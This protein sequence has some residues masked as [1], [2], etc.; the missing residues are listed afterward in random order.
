MVVL[1]VLAAG[2]LLTDFLAWSPKALRDSSQQAAFLLPGVLDGPTCDGTWRHLPAI[3]YADGHVCNRPAADVLPVSILSGVVATLAEVLKSGQ[4]V[5]AARLAREQCGFVLSVSTLPAVTASSLARRLLVKLMTRM[6]LALLPLAPA[7]WQRTTR[8]AAL[9]ATLSKPPGSSEY[10]AQ[11]ASGIGT[12]TAAGSSQSLDSSPQSAA[13]LS[14]TGHGAALGQPH[15]AGDN[16][17]KSAVVTISD[18]VEDITGEL[19][20]ALRNSDTVVR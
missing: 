6:A 15:K 18:A 9:H 2:E 17:D 19:L 3:S 5:Q 7:T 8:I 13:E 4:P 1:M 14:L 20:Q 11:N 10:A 16:K 12:G